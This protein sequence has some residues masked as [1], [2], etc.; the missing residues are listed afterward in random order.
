MENLILT[1]IALSI[2]SFGMV[3][4]RVQKSIVT[5]PMVFVLFG[6]LMSHNLLGVIQFSIDNRFIH[7][8]AEITLVLV[9][10][11]DA[12]RI[13]LRILRRQ[14]N[15][16]LRML[17]FGLPLTI[18]FGFLTALFLFD[19]LAPFEALILAIILSPTDAALGQAV[20]SNK[21]VPVRIRQALNVESGLNDGIVLP[22]LLIAL[23]YA[24]LSEHSEN[25]QYWSRFAALQLTLGPLV[26]IAVGF[27]GGKMVVFGSKNKW[28]NHTFQD[29]SALGLSFLAFGAA[30]LIG[31]NG[32][33]AAFCAGLTLGNSSRNIC[34][35][36]YEF[37]EA[38]GQLLNLLVFMIFGGIIVPELIPRLNWQ[39]ITYAVLSLTL[40][41]MLPVAI[42]LLKA[43]LRPDTIFFLGWFGPRGLASILFSLMIL[44]EAHLAGG[45]EILNITMTTV[46]LS[47]FAHGITANPLARRYSERLGKTLH[48]PG[49]EEYSPVDE[50]PVRLPYKE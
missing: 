12:A 17:F 23:S 18:L 36:L 50:M 32:F 5:P 6:L 7:L 24:G 43:R 26:G 44:E 40:L 13:N 37:A 11:T 22:I 8:L 42:S 35:C 19:A 38:E 30:N 29:L 49:I 9:L 21:I 4:G 47:I 46:T 45:N 2:L 39:T 14:H 10:F 27:A 28:M 41:R 16:P 20:V 48:K 31:G 3:S 1:V 25:A 33:I 34:P 15:I